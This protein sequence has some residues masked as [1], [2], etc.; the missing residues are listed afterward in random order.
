MTPKANRILISIGIALLALMYLGDFILNAL[1][2]F[3]VTT[4]EE[5]GVKIYRLISIALK[6]I[7]WLLLFVFVLGSVNVCEKC[8]CISM[9]QTNMPVSYEP[10]VQTRQQ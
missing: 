6:S 5:Q 1:T 3:G 7:G 10:T 8:S 2:N 9:A 4:E